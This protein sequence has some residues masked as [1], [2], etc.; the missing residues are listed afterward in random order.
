MLPWDTRIVCIHATRVVLRL[1]CRVQGDTILQEYV[2]EVSK[3]D[4]TLHFVTYQLCSMRIV[5]I[6]EPERLRD[7][8]I[9]QEQVPREQ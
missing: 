2:S 4:I 5:T 6:F 9:V 7:I 8:H 3:T 1:P